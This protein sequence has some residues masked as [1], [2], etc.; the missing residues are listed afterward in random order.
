MKHQ[1]VV[2]S[3]PGLISEKEMSAVELELAKTF[4]TRQRSEVFG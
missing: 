3:L 1:S 2:K 4:Q